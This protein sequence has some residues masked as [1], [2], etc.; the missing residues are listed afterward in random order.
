M[1]KNFRKASY[2]I[3]RIIVLVVVW[4]SV[5]PVLASSY[6]SFHHSARQPLQ[7]GQSVA[8]KSDNVTVAYKNAISASSTADVVDGQVIDYF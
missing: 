3:A 5:A 1:M 6:G 7:S 8:Y 4:L 2:N